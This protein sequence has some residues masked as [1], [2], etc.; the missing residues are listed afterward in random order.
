MPPILKNSDLTIPLY[1]VGYD[2]EDEL[3]AT[4]A[5]HPELLREDTDVPLRTV[6]REVSMEGQYLDI[7]MVDATGM[8]I[9]VEV[10]LVKNADIRRKIVGQILEYASLLS[11][12]TVDELDSIARG[13][14]NETLQAFATE[15]GATFEDLRKACGTHLRAGQV[16][17]IIAVDETPE[18]LIQI[19][20][21]LSRRSDLDIRLVQLHKYLL[22]TG[23]ILVVPNLLVK[24]ENIRSRKLIDPRFM[25]VIFAY[26][27]IAP[28]GFPVWEED[29][30]DW[31]L[32]C[33][34][35]WKELWVHYEFCDWGKTI[36]VEIHLEDEPVK[37]LQELL[38]SF[39][40]DWTE[41]YPEREI[42]WDP[43][44]EDCGRVGILFPKK[45]DPAVIAG[46]MR[47]IIRE[48]GAE[49]QMRL[50][51]MFFR[52]E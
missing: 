14:L 25:Q 3:Q 43:D 31:R 35:A 12:L 45:T 8:P 40:E 51:R 6:R 17:I 30:P 1:Q 7:L 13:A 18:G 29:E 33:P 42:V 4:L 16:R 24:P 41:K 32:V 39:K 10:K 37:P 26:Q 47:E 34:S 9:A 27:D 50:D 46:T 48:T 19:F 21:F 23:E 44:W 28:E 20:E 15:G 5:Q 11:N 22:K 38:L 2:D 36:G 49:I 52:S